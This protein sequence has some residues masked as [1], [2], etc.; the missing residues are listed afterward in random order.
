MLLRSKYFVG[1]AILGIAALAATLALVLSSST[2]DIAAQEILVNAQTE[3]TTVASYRY[4]LHGWHTPLL[5]ED[6]DW[7]E[8][9]TSATV[10]FGEGVHIIV[11]GLDD[12]STGDYS[13][14]LHLDGKQYH[15]DSADGEWQTGRQPL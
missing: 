1:F 6:P 3:N 9:K 8:T 12:W 7:Y 4:E 14:V 15:R 10:V 2:K 11:E 13:E 5:P